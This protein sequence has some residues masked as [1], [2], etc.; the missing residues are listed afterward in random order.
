MSNVIKRYATL[1]IPFYVEQSESGIPFSKIFQQPASPSLSKDEVKIHL[2]V[3]RRMRSAATLLN[4]IALTTRF[5]K[6]KI[7][8]LARYNSSHS[9]NSLRWLDYSNS[10][11]I[12]NNFTAI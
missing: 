8:F 4:H 9:R 11:L 7:S 12:Y 2:T 5:N 6:A 1:G 3:K 10:F